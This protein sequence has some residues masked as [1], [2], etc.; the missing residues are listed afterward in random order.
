VHTTAGE[1]KGGSNNPSTKRL[2]RRRCARVRP[3][4]KKAHTPESKKKND[5][6]HT[7]QGGMSE[8]MAKLETIRAKNSLRSTRK[9]RGKT[10]TTSGLGVCLAWSGGGPTMNQKSMN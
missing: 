3:R 4:E 9:A 10:T 1:R 5:E 8:R 6:R 7:R 2:A